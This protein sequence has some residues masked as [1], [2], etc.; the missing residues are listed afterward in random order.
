MLPRIRSVGSK[1]VFESAIPELGVGETFVV[2][3]LPKVGQL[4]LRKDGTRHVLVEPLKTT[5]AQ[6]DADAE[7]DLNDSETEGAEIPDAMEGAATP[8]PPSTPLPSVIPV[9]SF[10]PRIAQHSDTS[11]HIRGSYWTVA[12]KRTLIG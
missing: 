10:I 4:R 7:D 9:Q 5:I 8:D 11:M 1:F 2:M 3:V 12:H 6:V